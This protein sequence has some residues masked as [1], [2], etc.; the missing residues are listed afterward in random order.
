MNDRVLNLVVRQQTARW[1]L[2][3]RL[4][5]DDTGEGVISLAIGVLIMALLGAVLW[6]AF[7][8]TLGHATTNVDDQVTRIG[9]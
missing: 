4:T 8:L 1:A 6:A 5:P 2:T 9:S 7:R 3:D